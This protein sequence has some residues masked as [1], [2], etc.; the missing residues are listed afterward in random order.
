MADLKQMTELAEKLRD[1]GYEISGEP[2]EEKKS[3]E[4]TPEPDVQTKGR[5]RKGK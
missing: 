4:E 3:D 2:D 5:T 1:M